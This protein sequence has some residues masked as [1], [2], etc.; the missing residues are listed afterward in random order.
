MNYVKLGMFAVAFLFAV[1]CGSPEQQ[2]ISE[3]EV[4]VVIESDSLSGELSVS[5][6]SVEQKVNELRE[7]LEN[8]NN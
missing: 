7:T 6:D 2:E 5:S 4:Q 8:L 1:S 3:E